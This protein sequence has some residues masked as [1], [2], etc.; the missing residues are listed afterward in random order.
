MHKKRTA[1]NFKIIV[2]CASALFSAAS[3]AAP[4]TNFPKLKPGLW[5]ITMTMQ[6]KAMPKMRQ[7][8]DAKTQAESEKMALDYADKDCKDVKYSQSGNVFFAEATCKLDGGKTVHTKTETTFISANE[9]KTKIVSEQDGKAETMLNHTK[10]VGDCSAQEGS[11]GSIADENGN[12][13]SLDELLKQA[14]E[15]QKKFK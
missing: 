10:R 15:A 1:L 11:L 3:F 8:I 4:P 6:G 14:K 7:C 9:L 2:I 12:M 13:Q 5:E